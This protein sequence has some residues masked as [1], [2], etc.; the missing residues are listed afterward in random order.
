MANKTKTPEERI[1]SKLHLSLEEA[2]IGDYWIL[3]SNSEKFNALAQ[4]ARISELSNGQRGIHFPLQTSYSQRTQIWKIA[5]V[6]EQRENFLKS[7]GKSY[8]I[9]TPKQANLAFEKTYHDTSSQDPLS[10]LKFTRF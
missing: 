5:L 6:P 2:K 7:Y 10:H 4:K 9:R 1:F 3:I 8:R